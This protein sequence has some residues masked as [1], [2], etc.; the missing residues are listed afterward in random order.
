MRGLLAL[1]VSLLLLAATCAISSGCT[2]SRWAKSDADYAAKYRHHSDNPLQVAKQAMDARFMRNRGGF[3][4]AT[5][6]GTDPGTL[7]GELTGFQYVGHS[8]ELRG[9]L[10]GVAGTGNSNLFG[11]LTAGARVQTPTRLAPFVGIG[12]LAASGERDVS[13]DGLDNDNNLLI[14]ETGED[15]SEYFA[16]VFPETGLHFWLTPRVRLTTSAAYH[17]TTTGRDDDQWMFGIGLSLLSPG[18]YAETPD[19][20]FSLL[21]KPDD[22][23]PHVLGRPE[24]IYSDLA[25][26]PPPRTQF[27]RTPDGRPLPP[28]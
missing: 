2:S 16:S 20:K 19:G 14:D 17:F 6:L 9:G 13:D 5:H 15:L 4:V 11:G 7:G 21:E 22:W 25:P 26:A 10:L 12:G 3:G 8:L 18:D 24:R 1:R 23:Q 27:E 28:L